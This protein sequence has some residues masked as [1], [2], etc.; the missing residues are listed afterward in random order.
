MLITSLWIKI[1][2]LVVYLKLFQV[3]VLLSCV[4]DKRGDLVNVSTLTT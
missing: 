1:Q 2:R 4:L 3:I